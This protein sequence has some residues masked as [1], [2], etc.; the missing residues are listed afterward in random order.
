MHLRV[1]SGHRDTYLTECPGD[2]L[3]RLLP[4]LAKRVASSGGP[5]IYTPVVS[6]EVGGP[7]RFTAKLSGSAPWTVTV[8]DVTGAEVASW[9]DVGATVD[10]TW[11]SQLAVPR[12]AYSV[13]DLRRR[14]RAR[15]AARSAA[16][17]RRSRSPS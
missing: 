5:K 11:D 14:A 9:S 12:V 17:S 8:T 10:W 15:Q 16:S 13:D 6:G 2:A 3:Y 7:V 4:A 1:V